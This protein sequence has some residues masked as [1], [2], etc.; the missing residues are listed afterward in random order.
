MHNSVYGLTEIGLVKRLDAQL[1]LWVNT[2]AVNVNC[3]K[4]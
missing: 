4:K 2:G 1:R 3:L